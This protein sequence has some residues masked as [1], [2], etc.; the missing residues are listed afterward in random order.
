MF[1]LDQRGTK[2]APTTEAVA[3]LGAET[4]VAQ[5][6]SSEGARYSVVIAAD[7]IVK[8]DDRVVASAASIDTAQTAVLDYL[9]QQ[10]LTVSAP[11]E[12]S[13][14]DQ[15]RRTILSIRVRED[16]SSEL[17][18]DPVSLTPAEAPPLLPPSPP[19]VPP[20]LSPLIQADRVPGAE[21]ER[22]AQ[23]EE[24]AG[25]STRQDQETAVLTVIKASKLD[26]ASPEAMADLAGR[27]EPGPSR[28]Q[29]PER[30]PLAPLSRLADE[31]QA[32]ASS[33]GSLPIPEELAA[34]VTL[35]C[36]TVTSGELTLA[37][38]QASALERQAARRF[39][40][41]HYYTLEARALEAY[42][43]HLLGDHATAAALALHVAEVRHRQGDS[44]VHDDVKRAAICWELLASPFAAV[45]L[46]KRLLSLWKLVGVPEDGERYAAAER[47]LA[48]LS[49]MTPPAFAAALGGIF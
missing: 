16:G 19:A 29:P 32:S 8:V 36:E 25:G 43:A 33:P 49:R 10:A 46:G 22:S 48:V 20:T 42:V 9:H 45:P 41:E 30:A 2:P 1:G 35:V 12:A 34:G 39:G 40:Q 15:Q 7:G 3:T 38:V 23:A 5:E 47:R 14:L 27:P 28:L 26:D 21:I 6:G 44:R 17:L 18:A 4:Q 24:T 11:V 37:K 31:P 13:V